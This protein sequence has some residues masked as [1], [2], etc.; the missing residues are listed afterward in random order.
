MIKLTKIIGFYTHHDSGV[1]VMRIGMC[2]HVISSVSCVG[3]LDVQAS[4]VWACAMSGDS[5]CGGTEIKNTV[6][7]MGWEK[8]MI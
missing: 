3:C 1:R 8:V 5:V 6:C 4:D 2:E 7:K